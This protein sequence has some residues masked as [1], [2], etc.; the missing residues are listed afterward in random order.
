MSPYAYRTPSYFTP[1]ANSP[2]TA[3]QTTASE[4]PGGT[5]KTATE[6][7]DWLCMELSGSMVAGEAMESLRQVARTLAPDLS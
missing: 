3:N 4:S 1:Y 7:K 5:W 2:S 6:S